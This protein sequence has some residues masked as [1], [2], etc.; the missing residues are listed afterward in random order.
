MSIHMSKSNMSICPA[1][2]TPGQGGS[3]PSTLSAGDPGIW[4]S[5]RMKLPAQNASDGFLI[6]ALSKNDLCKNKSFDGDGNHA[7][8]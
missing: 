7:S 4:E 5:K 2:W 8:L 6:S 3:C 1:E